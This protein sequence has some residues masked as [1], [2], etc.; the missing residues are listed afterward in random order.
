MNAEAE[1]DSPVST[2]LAELVQ[3]QAQ[4]RG[5]NKSA[6]RRVKR[7][8]SGPAQSRRLG[9][10]LDFAE[11]R[12]YQPGD[13]VRMIDWKVTAR[14]G[15]AHTKLFVEEK[16]RPVFLCVD[17]RS[18]MRFA[19]RGVF[20][21]ALAQRL[22]ALIG[23]H[24]VGRADRVGGLVFTDHWHSEIKPRSGS[25][26]L[27]MLFHALQSAATTPDAELATVHLQA[28]LE[29]LR[30]LAHAGSEIYLFS[31]MLGFDEAC[32]STL[33]AMLPH[34]DI[35]LVH[36]SD[37]LERK[38]PP[39]GRYTLAPLAMAPSA[40]DAASPTRMVLQ[41]GQ[42]QLQDRF[43][44]QWQQRSEILSRLLRSHRGHY[45]VVDTRAALVDTA[46]ALV[47]RLDMAVDEPDEADVKAARL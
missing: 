4:A 16:E 26:G 34:A 46:R 35:T 17:A 1:F 40:P 39:R 27:M 21:V 31:D 19:T 13:D 23:W 41:T 44:S 2:T 45:A 33:A 32:E 3:L 7:L 47:G 12:G 36:L 8:R 9:R 18:T 37:S 42:Q 14:T 24:A 28:Q 22:A 38:L 15:H 20:K 6:A 25:A 11:V 29:R 30:R 5:L 10:G 43:A